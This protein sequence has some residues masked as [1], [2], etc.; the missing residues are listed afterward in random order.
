MKQPPPRTHAS[1]LSDDELVIFDFLWDAGAP[2]SLLYGQV[3]PLHANTSYSHSIPD[4]ELHGH[5]LALV[6]RGLLEVGTSDM[7][8]AHAR[9]P[10]DVFDLTGAGFVAWESERLPDWSRYIQDGCLDARLTVAAPSLQVG[11]RFVEV[12]RC[13]GLWNIADVEALHR[14]ETGVQLLP[15]KTFD[16]VH[17]FDMPTLEEDSHRQV[18]WAQ[19]QSERIWWRTIGELWRR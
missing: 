8:P 6:E 4:S 17:F 7:G 3:L 9:C 14:V 15:G 12:C 2:V 10:T 11:M 13:T 5:L 18:D 16:E 19:Y 1:S